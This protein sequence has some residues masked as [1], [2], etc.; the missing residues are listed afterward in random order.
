MRYLAVV[1][2]LLL[3]VP[4]TA[5]NTYTPGIQ[6]YVVGDVLTIS[7]NETVVIAGV[8]TG[9]ATPI[10]TTYNV[11][12]RAGRW[13][14]P[15]YWHGNFQVDEQNL[16][17]NLHAY[18]VAHAD[19]VLVVITDPTITG[20]D[21]Q[22]TG[23][24]LAEVLAG[25]VYPVEPAPGEPGAGTPL[26]VTGDILNNTYA[27]AGGTLIGRE[28][29]DNGQI[30]YRTYDVVKNGDRWEID[31][32]DYNGFGLPE[33]T[34]ISMGMRRLA[35]ADP[36]TVIIN[37]TITNTGDMGWYHLSF[38]EFL[39]GEGYGP[40]LW[41]SPPS[42]SDQPRYLVGDVLGTDASNTTGQVVARVQWTEGS[43]P[44][45]TMYDVV[46]NGDRWE[47]EK[48]YNGDLQIDA[49]NVF[50]IG[51]HRIDH[52]D[53][54]FVIVTDLMITPNDLIYGGLSL[55]EILGGTPGYPF[56]EV[57]PTPYKALTIPGR[58]EAEDYNLGGE[59]IAYHDTTPGNAGGAYRQ[60]DVDIEANPAEGTPDVGWIRDG[61]W[62][63]YT[64]NVTQAGSYT[65]TARVASPNNDRTVVLSIDGVQF[66]TITIPNT[67]SF[68]TFTN[69]TPF[70]YVDLPP[71]TPTPGPTG[72]TV[73]IPVTLTAGMHVLNLTFSGDGQNIN[74]IEF[75]KSTV[76]IGIVPGGTG[77]SR[78]LN[79]DG[80]YEDVNGNG[81]FDFNDVVLFFNQMDW[82]TENEPV[83]AFDFAGDGKIDFNDVVMLFNSL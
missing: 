80:M 17:V 56:E 41:D 60:D 55:G 52:R 33:E 48:Y 78:D 27:P 24:S 51:W 71:Q 3:I 29:T 13:E 8:Q 36:H 5:D 79:G 40:E 67:G 23:L 45:Y 69:V 76:P 31:S 82:I 47:I 62:L 28:Y 59:G 39:A 74:W 65:L 26:Y 22:Y 21:M 25:I 4:V 32:F 83:A 2:L 14:I 58:I 63:T 54:H 70:M 50:S 53:P 38:A 19:P 73:P 1:L 37:D 43:F 30:Y 10:Y 11:V 64:V 16:V 66:P 20:G 42:Q 46:K 9:G 57:S 44:I 77:I 15:K 35:H 34:L 7:T 72:S 81:V 49:L 12:S 68:D 6:R 18:R 75:T 61:E